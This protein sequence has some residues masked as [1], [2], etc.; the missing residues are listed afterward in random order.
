VTSMGLSTLASGPVTVGASGIVFCCLGAAVVFGLRFSEMLPLR[1]R[2][3][4]G[5]VVVGYAAVMFY[6]G[7]QRPTTDNWGHAGGLIAGL[8]A[9]ALLEPRL[10]RVREAKDAAKPATASWIASLAIV[11]CV[12]AAGPL[13]PRV[14]FRFEPYRFDAF[15]I[16]LYRPVTWSKGPDPLGFLAFGNGVDAL[17]SIACA[18]VSEGRKLEDATQRFIDDELRALARAG[19]IGDLEVRAVTPA[20]VSGLAAR[21]VPFSFVASDGAFDARAYVFVRG[22][23]ECAFV[24]ASRASA[25]VRSRAILDEIRARIVFAETKAERD[26]RNAVLNRPQD[27]RAH[28][29]LALA[30]QASGDIVGARGSLDTAAQ[31]AARDPVWT[32]RIELA[33]GRMELARGEDLGAAL[34]AAERAVAAR[35]EEPDSAVLLLDVLLAKQDGARARDVAIAALKVFPNDERVL[36]RRTAAD[37]LPRA[38]P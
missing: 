19:H 4:F 33:R 5:V 10:M 17:T 28:L 29:D 14:L 13:V 37:A 32:A 36:A 15:G 22:E 27:P 34:A 35:P 16:D 11:A 1:Y 23:T 8:I 12:A 21:E 31:L 6:L 9:G 7:L 25:S 2:L 18:R 38:T 30:H 3:Y 20:Q 26:G 24:V